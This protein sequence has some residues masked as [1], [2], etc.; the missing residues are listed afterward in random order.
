[1]KIR[2]RARETR[3][4]DDLPGLVHVNQRYTASPN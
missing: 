3:R 2:G 4:G 1:M